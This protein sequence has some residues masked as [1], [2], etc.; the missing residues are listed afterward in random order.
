[1]ISALSAGA[2]TNTSS[3]VAGSTENLFAACMAPFILTVKVFSAG[4][5]SKGNL[6]FTGVEGVE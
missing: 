1:M 4:F 3:L 2:V 5:S 6:F